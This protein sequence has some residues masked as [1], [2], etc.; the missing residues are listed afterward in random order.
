MNELLQAAGVDVVSLAFKLKSA[1]TEMYWR[2]C[3]ANTLQFLYRTAP[4]KLQ[5]KINSCLNI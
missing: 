2:N 3:L 5:P 4:G 1:I